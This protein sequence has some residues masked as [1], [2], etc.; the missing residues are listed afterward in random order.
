MRYDF[1]KR[2]KREKS[3]PSVVEESSA[4]K[5]GRLSMITFHIAKRQDPVEGQ[6][7]LPVLCGQQV[8]FDSLWRQ[9][10]RWTTI[11]QLAEGDMESLPD[12]VKICEDCLLLT[13]G[14]VG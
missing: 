6:M 2:L 13:L 11:E 14:E 4:Y 1:W 3:E 8:Y 7:I 10:H 9:D 5:R 12:H